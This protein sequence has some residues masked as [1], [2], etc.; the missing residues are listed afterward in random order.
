MNE[1]ILT[2]VTGLP[3][4][5]LHEYSKILDGTWFTA[6]DVPLMVAYLKQGEHVILVDSGCCK[7]SYRNNFMAEIYNKFPLVKFKIIVYVK[8]RNLLTDE[9]FKVLQDFEFPTTEEL[10]INI[11]VVCKH[12]DDNLMYTGHAHTELANKMRLLYGNKSGYVSG[13]TIYDI[14]NSCIKEFNTDMVKYTSNIS[15]YIVAGLI[16]TIR[17]SEEV[18]CDWMQK[19]NMLFIINYSDYLSN[20]T[21]NEALSRFGEDKTKVLMAFD[22][23]RK[24]TE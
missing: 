10:F 5:D 7:Y 11:K 9:D 4:D 14:S 16:E 2:I 20:H 12:H 21:I 13:A 1:S 22:T 3:G 17:L 15:A 23:I 18:L 8:P 19:L 24:L 6:P